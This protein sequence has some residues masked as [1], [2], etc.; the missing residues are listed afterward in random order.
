MLIISG[1]GSAIL[2]LVTNIFVRRS[3]HPVGK[4]VAVSLAFAFGTVILLFVLPAVTIQGLLTI[5]AVIAWRC[6][7][8]PPA[9]F[10]GLSC[11]AAVIA[12]SFAGW[13]AWQDQREFARLRKLFPYESM[14]ARVPAPQQSAGATKLTQAAAHRLD[15]IEKQI[16]FAG[17]TVR[18]WEL[19][20]L[21]EDAVGLFVNSPGFGVARM[22]RPSAGVLEFTRDRQTVPQPG[23]RV[24]ATWSPGDGLGAPAGDK[25]FLGL[26]LEDS[27][28]EFV[29]RQGWGFPRDRRHVA[30]FVSHRFGRVPVPDDGWRVQDDL[31]EK[32]T[33]LD[34]P[35]TRWQVQTL[36]LVGLLLHEEPVVYVS[37]RLPAMDKLD[38]A[39]TRPLN[40]F[41]KLAMATLQAGDDLVV[42]R[43]GDGLRMLGG[44]RS[45]K[46]CVICHG[47][48]RGDLLGAF[49][50]TLKRPDR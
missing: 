46:Q 26:L 18:T 50:Y 31:T 14:E 24:E 5:A 21:H 20:L 22:M 8:R 10:I 45:S 49:S 34:P 33:T 4:T 48:Q 7:G 40:R 44:I 43:D 23:P 12:Y 41:E 25:P 17:D 36:D 42:G 9:L 35:A 30:G 47:G 32:F 39:P 19:E 16:E 38:G 15:K 6:S 29:F 2:L 1:T 28:G 3:R 13:W 11:A 37:E 27:V